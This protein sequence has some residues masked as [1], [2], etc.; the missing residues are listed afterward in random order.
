M[1]ILR[2]TRRQSNDQQNTTSLDHLQSSGDALSDG[3][4]PINHENVDEI[5]DP[6]DNVLQVACAL[7]ATPRQGKLVTSTTADG[8]S[9]AI[10]YQNG[11]DFVSIL[12]QV[13]SGQHEV[14]RVMHVDYPLP[15]N[16]ARTTVTR[17]DHEISGLDDDDTACLMSKNAFTMPPHS[18][19]DEFLRAYFTYA[20][21]YAPI[22]DRSFAVAMNIAFSVELL[23]ATTLSI[24]EK[25]VCEEAVLNSI[26]YLT[27][28]E[29][30]WPRIR[31]MLR[32]F[33]WVFEQKGLSFASKSECMQFHLPVTMDSFA[34]QG[35]ESPMGE[36]ADADLFAMFSGLDNPVDMADWLSLPSFSADA[37]S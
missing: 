3:T 23:S 29:H 20:Y 13:V 8:F 17:L 26:S 2:R 37:E 31:E 19:C 16:P 36:F 33:S 14:N 30:R 5:V 7:A 1:S 12:G 10:Q 28:V 21:P 9:S 35:F 22:L 4:A 18:I 24:P 32:L 34:S 27:H 15:R 6:D 25:G 11:L